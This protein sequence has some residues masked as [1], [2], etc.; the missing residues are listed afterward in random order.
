MISTVD[1]SRSVVVQDV[2]AEGQRWLGVRTFERVNSPA[3]PGPHSS[4]IRVPLI[5]RKMFA[6]AYVPV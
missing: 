3:D 1:P 2:E 6:N 4:I 5:V